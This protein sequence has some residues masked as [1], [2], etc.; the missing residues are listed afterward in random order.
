MK[1]LVLGIDA[2]VKKVFETFEMPFLQSKLSKGVIIKT[3]EDIVTRGWVK[4]YTGKSAEANLGFYEY[5]IIDKE[6]YQWS[7]SFNQNHLK[8]TGVKPLWESLKENDISSGFMNIPTTSPAPEIKGFFISGGGGG[9]E[10]KN[11]FDASICFP[12][13]YTEVLN[14]NDYILDERVPSLVW[15]K[16]LE[17]YNVFFEKLIEMTEKRILTYIELYKKEPVDFGFLVIRSVAVVHYLAMSEI[18]NFCNLNIPINNE[19]L[20]NLKIFYKKLDGSIEKLFLSLNPENYIIFADHGIS[21]LNESININKFLSS[22]GFQKPIVSKN[23]SKKIINKM[24]HLIPYKLRRKIKR[25][26]SFKEYY[27]S[28]ISFETKNTKAFSRGAVNG[29]YINDESRFN[30]SVKAEEADQI[31][32]EIISSI[33]NNYEFK[34]RQITAK[35][36]RK[37]HDSSKKY[38]NYLP[39]IVLTNIKGLRFT[40]VGNKVFLKN[41]FVNKPY[42]LKDVKDDNWTGVKDSETLLAVSKKLHKKAEDLV[43]DD[44]DL[45]LVYQLIK[46]NFNI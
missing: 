31:I 2:G 23:S 17:K 15:E 13:S 39:D 29:I 9:K 28:M 8:K 1:L 34:K 6:G 4:S 22:N 36:F 25:S 45:T 27:M 41:E 20:D 42:N 12:E 21:T 5:P 14:S 46:R 11:G 32:D 3:T 7:K 18:D 37:E 16:G 10:L 35:R 43:K 30:G 24:K 38:Y 26:A 33:N 40:E 19:L 44:N